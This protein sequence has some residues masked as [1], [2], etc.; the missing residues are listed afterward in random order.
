MAATELNQRLWSSEIA[1]LVVF[2]R[3]FLKSRLFLVFFLA[4][5]RRRRKRQRE[6]PKITR[7]ATTK[8]DVL[9]RDFRRPKARKPRIQTCVRRGFEKKERASTRSS[10]VEASSTIRRRELEDIVASA[11]G[12][13]AWSEP[14]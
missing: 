2:N 13:R 14:L 12:S 1:S 5:M 11:M 10:F 8:D 7:G 9:R 4:S 6:R 3:V